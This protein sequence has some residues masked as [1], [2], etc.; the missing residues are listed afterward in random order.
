MSQTVSRPA[1]PPRPQRAGAAAVRTVINSASRVSPDL[2]GRLA[3]Q[4]WRRPGRPVEV[5]PDEREVH[6][7]ARTAYVENQHGRVTTYAWGDGERPVLLVHGWGARASRF[8]AVVTA[9]LEAGRSPVAYDAWGHG[10]TP[11]GART[12]PDHRV[13]IE[14][15]AER[16]GPFEGVVAHSFGV[17]VAL[18]AARDGLVGDRV[19]A[20]SGMGEF[21]YLVDTFCAELGV[22]EPVNAALRRSI[23]RTFFDGDNTIWERL[24]AG[25]LPGRD[26]LVVHDSGDRVVDRRQADVLVGVLGDRAQLV[27][28]S[29]L[30]HSRIL[31][32]PAVVDA[33]ASFVTGGRR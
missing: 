29:G 14:R 5:R 24:S 12:I 28:T 9:L 13:V 23:E 18:Y 32:D 10:A 21:G 19:V 6:D 22:R 27:E 7:A 20:I 4:L 33:A 30:G 8:G 25:P 16:H 2:A 15:L 1:A 3:L 26:V 17:P 11:G 31:R